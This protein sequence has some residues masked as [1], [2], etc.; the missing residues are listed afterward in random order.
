[1]RIGSIE[2]PVIVVLTATTENI[3]IVHKSLENIVVN[4]TYVW[5]FGKGTITLSTKYPRYHKNI[6]AGDAIAACK[7]EAGTVGLF[8]R[9]PDSRR[10]HGLI[11]GH[12]FDD[13]PPGRPVIHPAVKH[14]TMDITDVQYML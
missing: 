11:A 2:A 3:D 6:H 4:S 7:D 8:I 9:K 5:L 13:L 10:I 1:M 14:L 12:V